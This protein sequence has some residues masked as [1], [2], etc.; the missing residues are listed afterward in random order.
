MMAVA[1]TA[2]ITRAFCAVEAELAA[3]FPTVLLRPTPAGSDRGMALE[4]TVKRM[5]I[6][7]TNPYILIYN[8]IDL[9]ILLDLVYVSAVFV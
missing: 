2:I 4:P 3:T 5:S 6:H 9:L 1:T 7:L 8:F